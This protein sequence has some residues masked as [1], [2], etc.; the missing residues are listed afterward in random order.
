MN[1]PSKKILLMTLITCLLLPTITVN[2][3][4]KPDVA[5]PPGLVTMVAKDGKTSWF[6]FNISDVPS[7]YDITSGSYKGWCLQ[8]NIFMSRGVN[9]SVYLLSSYDANLNQ[10]FFNKNWS[11][12]NYIL[13]HKNGYPY[14]SVQYA[15][16]YF[17]DDYAYPTDPDAQ[18]MIADANTNGSLFY[19]GVSEIMA[20]IIDSVPTSQRAFL[21]LTVPSQSTGGPSGGSTTVNH[22]PT[23]DTSAGEPYNGL[24]G[25]YITFDGSR[26]YD[27]DG[28]I[29]SWHWDFGDRTFGDA[30]IMTHAYAAV[31]V[32]NV[33]LT[34]TDNNGATDIHKTIATIRVENEPPSVPVV[35]GIVV[36]TINTVYQYTAVSTDPENDTIR[37]IFTWNDGT[38]ATVT[39]L[40]SSGIT[41]NTTHIWPAAGVYH[42]AVYAQ[43]KYNASSDSI[44]ML[45][46]IDVSVAFLTGNLSGYL[47]DYG[48]TGIFTVFHNN[49]TGLDSAVELEANG[50]Y[51]IDSDHDGVWDYRY[52]VT[53][54][55]ATRLSSETTPSKVKT[56]GFEFLLVVCAIV[57]LGL[58]RLRK[59][60]NKM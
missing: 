19:P 48:L 28:S 10:T 44:Q 15:I 4:S 58:L 30:S 34:V 32:Y 33:S 59:N 13:N 23:A 40:S 51:L 29:V 38:N 2:A 49:I 8:R 54:G 25:Q 56:P 43:D 21:E 6:N 5:L 18:A 55:V 26:S 45:V 36:G 20:V 27:R 31:G 47:I 50:T 9:H 60:H 46:L 57:I 1:K 12:I 14:K 42:V 39:N 11:K 3:A 17:Y 52:N 41:V 16:W 35:T 22:P 53:T 37:Y 24:V 7:G